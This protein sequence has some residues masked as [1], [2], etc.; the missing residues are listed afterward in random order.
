MNLEIRS[1][2]L[3]KR[4]PTSKESKSYSPNTGTLKSFKQSLDY[5]RYNPNSSCSPSYTFSK[6]DRFN[7]DIFEKFKS[8]L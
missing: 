2:R 4:S 1:G 8:K 7:S 3:K 6:L 5:K